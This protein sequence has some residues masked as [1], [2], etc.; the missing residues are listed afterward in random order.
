VGDT[1]VKGKRKH[2]EGGVK[3]V[4]WH[5]VVLDEA[6]TIRNRTTKLFKAAMALKA[7][8]KWAVTGAPW[9][10]VQRGCMSNRSPQ[11]FCATVSRTLILQTR[12]CFVFPR[13]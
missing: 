1:P 9:L 7:A 11:H 3:E 2:N 12:N 6:H 10:M 5:R 8:H 4:A 13:N